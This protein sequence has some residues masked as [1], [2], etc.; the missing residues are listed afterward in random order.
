MILKTYR[1]FLS[2]RNALIVTAALSSTFKKF[3]LITFKKFGFSTILLLIL[4]KVQ[5][6]CVNIKKMVLIAIIY[7]VVAGDW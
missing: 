7:C 6:Y 4:P 1:G 5:K 2:N 3:T